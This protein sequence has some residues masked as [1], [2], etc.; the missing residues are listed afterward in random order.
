MSWLPWLASPLVA[1][2]GVA[3][4][5]GLL[6]LPLRKLTSAEAQPSALS[7]S[8][9]LTKNEV[10]AV[11]RLHLLVPAKLV[12]LRSSEGKELIRA[13]DLEAGK[14]EYDLRIPFSGSKID[15]ALEADMGAQ[16]AD[17]AI[18]VTLMPDAHEE[19]TRFVIGYGLIHDSLHFKWP[20]P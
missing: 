17:T 16:A 14:S 19:E 12:L 5:L 20:T 13:N 4:C 2:A 15:L 6:A 18:F 9:V 1:T 11:L 10:S 7:E 3:T 8:V